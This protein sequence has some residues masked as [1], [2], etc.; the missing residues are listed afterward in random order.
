MD[1]LFKQYNY[2]SANKFYQI[3]K[4]NNIKATHNQVKEFIEK[5][6]VSQ[7]HKKIEKASTNILSQVFRMKYSK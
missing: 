4:E 5:Q 6:A 7:V 2:P 3:L 1:A